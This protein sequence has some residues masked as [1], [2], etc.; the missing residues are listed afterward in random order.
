MDRPTPSL[1]LESLTPPDR[2]ITQVWR[3]FPPVDRSFIRLI[4]WDLVMLAESPID[5]TFLRTVI[6]F[7]LLIFG[8]LMFPH[9]SNLIDRALAQVVLQAV[10]GNSYVE[11]LLA[12]TVRSLDYVREIRRGKMKGSPHLLQI[13]LLAHIRPFCSSHMFSCITDDCSLIARLLPVFQPSERSFSEWRQFLEELTLTQFLW[14]AYWNPGGPMITRLYVAK[15]Y[16]QDSVPIH[17]PRTTPIPRVPPA[18]TSEAECYAQAAMRMKLQ[19]IREER[20]RLR[21]ELVDTRA[22]LVDYRELQRELVQ[23]RA[24]VA[25]QDKEIARLSAMLNRA[26]VKAHNVSHP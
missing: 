6:K 25:N 17:R 24:H 22:K 15:F 16:S 20:N 4:I 21:C 26:W 23:A 11:A 1:R 7:L 14:A 3:A 13:W 9:A 8:T 19:S 5:W 12:E 18:V 10:G 2:E